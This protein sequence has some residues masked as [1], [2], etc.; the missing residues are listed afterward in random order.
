MISNV[1]QTAVTVILFWFVLRTLQ[2]L[3]SSYFAKNIQ[4]FGRY[5]YISDVSW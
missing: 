2:L 3:N 1:K 4:F 5:T